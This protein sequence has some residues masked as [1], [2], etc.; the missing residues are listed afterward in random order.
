MNLEYMLLR[1]GGVWKLGKRFYVTLLLTTVTGERK[2][3]VMAALLR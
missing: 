1:E 3:D 2:S